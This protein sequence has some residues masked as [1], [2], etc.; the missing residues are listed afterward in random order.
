MSLRIV[1]PQWPVVLTVGLLLAWRQEARADKAT[2]RSDLSSLKIGV[3]HE[4]FGRAVVDCGDREVAFVISMDEEFHGVLY[5]RGNFHAKN[6]A[7]YRNAEGGKDFALKFGYEDCGMKYDDVSGGYSTTVIVQHDDDLIF[8]GDL[9]FA[10][11]C[12]REQQTES[13]DEDNVERSRITLVDADPAAGPPEEEG[14][15]HYASSDSDVA[16]LLPP[17]PVDHQEL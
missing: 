10:L 11:F 3:S 16:T 14:T 9:A 1:R 5:T 2:W 15:H 13:S 17:Q 12:R 6:T 7:C 4:G 8:P